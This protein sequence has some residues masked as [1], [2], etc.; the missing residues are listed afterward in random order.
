MKCHF[1]GIKGT[2]MS[3][4][5]QIFSDLGYE[6]QGSDVTNHIFTQE[7]LE[8]RGIKLLPFNENN[9]ESN[10]EVI[11]GNS[12]INHPETLKSYELGNK[13]RKYYEVL[14][15]FSIHYKSIAVSGSHGKTTT[16]SL[17]S[18]ILNNLVGCNYL[19]GDGTGYARRDNE[20][21]VFEACEYKRVFLNY[22]PK[23]SIITNIELEHVDY[24]KDIYDVLS[25]FQSFIK[26]TKDIVFAYGDDENVRSLK[27]NKVMF[28]G[29]NDNNDIVAKNVETTTNGSSFDVYINNKLYGNF[30]IPLFGKHMILNT[31]AVLGVCY[32]EGLKVEEVGKELKTFKGAKRRFSETKIDDIITIDDYAHH[33]TE[34]EAT[35][36]ATKQKYPDKEI[37]AVFKPNTYSRTK[38]FA[39][40]F[41]K[42]LDL[43]DKAYVTDIYCDREKP[44]DYSD[45]NAYLIIDN[46]KKGEY[47]SDETIDKLLKHKNSVILFM[48]CKNIYELRKKYE[49]YL[50]HKNSKKN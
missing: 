34:I 6:V 23:Y 26:Q 21:F 13:T 42:A 17:L 18:H 35:I 49:E 15:D 31:L 25:A 40:N 27:Y 11:I 43:A 9:I 24:Y 30:E 22:F 32:V 20:Y 47:I 19:I 45:V 37:I 36:T 3:A 8:K 41:V 14:K 33:P 44:E 1:V 12:F 5:A 29:F 48:S 2:G 10:M 28:Y 38:M 46:L 16:T 7:E 50:K 4:L 39:P